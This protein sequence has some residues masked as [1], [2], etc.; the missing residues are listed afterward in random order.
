MSVGSNEIYLKG[1]FFLAQ[2][3]SKA[4]T[5]HIVLVV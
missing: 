1:I 5:I 3:Q 2:I 4:L